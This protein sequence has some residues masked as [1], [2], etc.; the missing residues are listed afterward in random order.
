MDVLVACESSGRVRDEFKA[1]GHN[2][3]SCDI[4]PSER[5]GK[6]FQCD[7]RD[8]IHR[9]WDLMIGHP[10]CTRICNSGVQWLKRRNLWKDLDEACEFFLTLWN[11]PIDKIGLENPIPH[12]Y[13]LQRI[14]RKYDQ[15]I[16]PWQFGHEETK[17]TCLWL[18]NLPKLVPTNIVEGREG[19]CWKMPPGPER[20]MERSRTY[21]GIARAIASQWGGVAA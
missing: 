20:A 12:K 8:V 16:Q 21:I 19:A 9:G 17:A 4:K 3:W 13:A 15:I 18:K 7:V 2:A 5:R 10:D 1:L 6:H 11:A 14:G